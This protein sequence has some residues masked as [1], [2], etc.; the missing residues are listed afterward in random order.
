MSALEGLNDQQRLAATS[1]DRCLLIVAGPG[2]G[3]TKTLTAR[4]ANLVQSGVDPAHI[5]ALTFTNK[6]AREMAE[7]VSAALGQTRPP[8]ITTFH[9]LANRLLPP[10]STTLA[11]PSQLADIAK[12]VKRVLSV[13]G[14][15]ERDIALA[16]SR[17]K[18]QS[19]AESDQTVREVV[20]AYQAAMAEQGLHDFDDMLKMLHDYLRQQKQPFLHVLVDE[21]QDTND[22]QYDILTLLARDASLFAIGDPLQSIYG[23]RGASA[24]VFDRI[25]TDW[26]DTQV[27]RLETN[28]R[29]TPQ[30]VALAAGVFPD[31]PPL[32]AHR[33]EAGNAKVI[34]ALN[35]FGEAD[36]VVHAIEQSLG[37]STMLTGSQHHTADQQRTFRDF[38]VL[39]RTHATAKALQRALE[40]SGL[41]HQ[42][43]GEGS[44]FARPDISAVTACIGYLAG[45]ND[46]PKVKEMSVSQARHL[47]DDHK[48]R[49]LGFKLDELAAKI[50]NML[51]IENERNIT[52]IKQFIQSLARI[53]DMP[54]AEFMTYL[55]GIA[56]QEYYDPDA[57]AISLLTIHAAKGLEFSQVYLI[58]AEEGIL[59][60]SKKGRIADIGEERRLFYVAATRARDDLY[61]T[62]VRQR[63]KQ[64]PEL[65]R[66]VRELPPG[67]AAMEADPA[68]AAQITRIKKRAQ[69]RAQS[70]LF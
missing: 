14:M 48:A 8:V 55:A 20:E 1:D 22:L 23:F 29:S 21:F 16:V 59:P 4:I 47:L 58:G 57:E 68:M 64:K 44:P 39:Y 43:A 5:L 37:G 30:V 45:S 51:T 41:P 6:A 28:Y 11:S 65:S 7:R 25:T 3:K 38:A 46:P 54:P 61:M 56:Q 31:E 50:V 42:I 26:P 17:S 32:I 52:E 27:I 34:E 2:T 12:H 13:R 63:A 24:G 67:L 33:Q 19:A 10:P 69:K 18:N 62:F 40:A 15:S 70:S 35:E 53:K 36:W 49:L 9:A 66:F 60:L